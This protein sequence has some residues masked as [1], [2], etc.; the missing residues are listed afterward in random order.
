MQWVAMLRKPTAREA[1]MTFLLLLPLLASL[2][3]RLYAKIRRRDG[4]SVGLQILSEERDDDH[5]KYEIIAVHGLGASPEHTWT[6][7][8]SSKSKTSDSQ[9]SVHLL[10][11]LLMKDERFTDARILHFAYNSD[12]LVDACFETARDIGLRLIEALIEHRKT[13]PR[14]PLI[15]IGHS[16]GGIVI[17]EAL[18]SD[19]EDTHRIVEDTY[20]IIFLGTPHLGSP[21]AGFGATLAYLTGFLGSNTG[22]LLLLRSN[23]EML[24]NLSIAFQSCLE[25]KYQDLDKKTKIVS[26]CEQK[27]TYLLNWLYAGLIVP[28]VSATFGTNFIEVFKVDKDHSGLN[29]CPNSED[30]LYKVLTAQLHKIRPT[31]PPKINT[32]QQAVLDR[33]ISVIVTDAEFH[34]ELDDYGRGHLECLPQTREE[35]LKDIC[36]WLDDCTSSQK[37]LYW[38]QGKAGTGKS[39][40]ART[41]V[42]RMT[43]DNRTVANFFF[44]RGEGDRARLKRFCTTL[45][46]QLV[47]KLPSFAEV[48]QDALEADPSLPE[49]DPRVQFKKL[50][51]EPMLRQNSSNMKAII[52]IVDALDECDSNEDLTTLVQQL[53]QP[54]LQ[55][56]P[57]AQFLVK[58]FVTSRLDHHTRPISSKAPEQ[59]C[60]KT[61]LE[62]VTSETIKRDIELYLRF[63]LEKIDGLLDPLPK[64]DLWSN[65]SDVDNLKK[66]TERASPLFE[67]AAAACRF[68]GQTTVL[69]EP[70]DILND[71]L[72]FH[73]PGDLDMV[74]ESILKRRFSN[75]KGQY[76]AKAKTQFQNVVGSVISLADSVSVSCLALLIELSEPAIRKELRLFE[77]VL[78]VPSE[79]DNGST[80]KLFHESFRDFL[81][82]PETVE[83]LKIDSIK[84]HGLLA[85]RCQQLL[86]G[87]LR[88]NICKLK[89]PGTHR[90]QVADE[91]ID[92]YIPQ[93]VQ[94][95]CRFWIFHVKG[96]RSGI[97]DGDDW[98]SFLLTHFLNWLEALSLLG[99]TS[100]SAS[101][102][103]ELQTTV[104]PSDGVQIRT[105]LEDAERLILSFRHIIDA[106]PLQLY[107]SILTFAPAKSLVRGNFDKYRAKWISRIPNVDSQWSPCLQTLEGDGMAAFCVAFSSEGILAA[108]YSDNKVKIWDPIP[109]TCLQTIFSQGLHDEGILYLNGIQSLALSEAGKLAFRTFDHIT[110][111]DIHQDICLEKLELDKE[112]M[113]TCDHAGNSVVFADEEKVLFTGRDMRKVF[114]IDLMDGCRQRSNPP[115]GLLDRCRQRSTTFFDYNRNI[116]SPDGQWAA[117]LI[118]EQDIMI[119]NVNFRKKSSL[120]P[121]IGSD[122]CGRKNK[123][124]ACFSRDNRYFISNSGSKA[125]IWDTSSS[126][127]LQI[128]DARRNITAMTFSPDARLVA[129]GLGDAITLWDWK[130][131]IRL[132]TLTGHQSHVMS[133]AFSPTE[134]WLASASLDCTVKIWN[135]AVHDSEEDET[136]YYRIRDMEIAMG[137][138]RLLTKLDSSEPEYQI[139]DSFG[140][141]R[142]L[143][144]SA[145]RCYQVTI[146]TN[147]SI[148]AMDCE[149][150][151]DCEGGSLEIWEVKS[152][153]QLLFRQDFIDD[154]WSIALSANGERCIIGF[155]YEG[156]EVRES[157]KGQLLKAWHAGIRY[158]RGGKFTAISP[159]GERMAW[160]GLTP[161]EERRIYIEDLH[162]DTDTPRVFPFLTNV[163]HLQFSENGKRLVAISRPWKGAI[164]DAATGACLRTFA[165]LDAFA[166]VWSLNPN[167]VDFHFNVDMQYND[168]AVNISEKLKWSCEMWKSKDWAD[169]LTKY[170]ISPDGAWI[171]RHREKLLWILP[172]YRPTAATVSGSNIAIGRVSGPPFVIG[173]SD[174]DL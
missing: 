85:S 87:S 83:E 76:R 165:I 139:F 96:S 153:N 51:K 88:E 38:L 111:W 129:M 109:G 54:I 110:V 60:E 71:I 147:G 81:T 48:V 108:G 30:P 41:I 2:L 106:A 170:H 92:E 168:R 125:Q 151:I 47:R 8:P 138:Q 63:Q 67:F 94:Y 55:D 82:G 91:T 69:G 74:Y 174:E 90:S 107:S 105:F 121:L 146:S 166:P 61:E 20:G 32:L 43:R 36:D 167:F 133:L 100:E 64:G 39:T 161:R 99:R 137:G 24:V 120:K 84:T 86:R 5:V 103:K 40:I 25:R 3:Y 4:R 143:N 11:D 169:C 131:C 130:K 29:K 68:I 126:E 140:N 163:E 75:L 149:G 102:L 19:L 62:K 53:T 14:L 118:S 142:I 119:L 10:K 33:L 157:R 160:A 136:Y 113:F 15:F 141:K 18:S 172:E 45:A 95:A 78:V 93:E 23:G 80:V 148:L 115:F 56:D 123:W 116:L 73:I 155:L 34:P 173:F 52:I 50:I 21:V 132:Q 22:L 104:H 13:H 164:W 144:P 89:T 124:L 135:T 154:I 59:M 98:H 72:E 12:W 134:A 9:K 49:Q 42:S 66:L 79:G 158:G 128:L 159:D 7:K 1:I 6:C 171:M 31:A 122:G 58:Y 35:I 17:K 162:T 77:S 16:F 26:I 46:A 117:C 152:G 112:R 44:K 114:E 28:F 127:R 156:V 37:H 57:S 150:P 101:L 145:K 27:P 97:K 70:R 65:P